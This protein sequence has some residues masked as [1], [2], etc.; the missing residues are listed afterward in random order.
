M[1][2][3]LRIEEVDGRR[4]GKVNLKGIHYTPLSL[5][6]H[7]LRR[8]PIEELPPSRRYI[9]DL[10]C[11]SGSFLL[12]ATERLRDAFDANEADS[13]DDVLEHLRSHVIGNDK[14]D[15]AVLVARMRYLLTHLIEKRT[16]DGVPIPSRLLKKDG[17]TL[18][19]ADFGGVVP[20][21][22]VGNPPFQPDG[23]DQMANQFLRK[24]L[25]L[26]P[27]GGFLGMIMPAGFLKM[28]R[29]KCPETRQQL[30]NECELLE[31]W[32]MP[33]GTVGLDARQAPC[34]IVARKAGNLGGSGRNAV[35]FKTGYSAQTQAVAANRD[36]ARSTWTFVASGFP[37]KG[38]IPW[39]RDNQHMNKY[40]LIASPVDE[41]WNRID[42]GHTIGDICGDQAGTGIDLGKK[43]VYSDD[44]PNNYEPYLL[45]Q[46]RLCPYFLLR[47][48]W[49]DDPKSRGPYIDPSFALWPKKLLWPLYRSSKVIVCT[50]TNRNTRTQVVAA[51]DSSGVF[52]GH[53]F[54]CLGV[55][56]ATGMADWAQN[57]IRSGSKKDILLW[58]TAIINSP[59][60]HAWVAMSSP[61]RGLHEDVLHTIPIPKHFDERIPRL[62]AATK[63]VER[64]ANFESRP[65]WTMWSLR[66]PHNPGRDF[67]TIVGQV[68]HLLFQSYGLT[69]H[70]FEMLRNYLEGM[71]NP[72]VDGP[73]DAHVPKHPERRIT[74]TVTAISVP[75]QRVTLDLPRYSRKT[76]A[77]LEVV[78]PRDMPGWALRE[79]T[80]FTCLAPRDLREPD[81]LCANPWLLR[82]FRPLP[83]SYLSAE[84]LNQLVAHVPV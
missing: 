30:L 5:A 13:E 3:F 54:R 56:S 9:A 22:I 42:P 57:I 49:H 66:L 58:L 64:P 39:L 44:K 34:A 73:P 84:E 78:L 1:A 2:D 68:N 77:P 48:D 80:G 25:H 17:L 79:G 14:D 15:I 23:S 4:G 21:V 29:Q 53:H 43:G 36:D 24:A 47:Q 63:D 62:V 60:G 74:G 46:D 33:Q 55:G 26:L 27:P 61:P 31:V 41:L 67:E 52:P 8:I 45:T 50:D 35:L 6:R 59:V 32:E 12:A 71:T 82:D 40:R 28:R 20:T 70:D 75:A 7:I 76:G 72:W 51:L 19:V 37:G 16:G 11:G 69:A 38:S 10:A 65:V 83:Y 81:E 18:S